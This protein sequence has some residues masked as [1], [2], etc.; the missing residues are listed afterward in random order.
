MNQAHARVGLVLVLTTFTAC[1]EGL[2]LK[3]G[4]GEQ[5]FSAGLGFTHCSPLS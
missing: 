3:V 4:D 2:N 5:E 1:S